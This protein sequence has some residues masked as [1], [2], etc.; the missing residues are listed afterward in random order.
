MVK[1]INAVSKMGYYQGNPD[2]FFASF[3]K[4]AIVKAANKAKE[5][6]SRG[7]KAFQAKRVEEAEKA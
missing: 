7:D 2:V 6:G 1:Y 5:D 3:A 4:Y